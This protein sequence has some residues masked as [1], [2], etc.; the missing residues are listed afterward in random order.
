M[1]LFKSF[2]SKSIIAICLS[3][4]FVSCSKDDKSNQPTPQISQIEKADK[5]AAAF[6]IK[7]KL[8]GMAVASVKDDEL[9][10]SK[11]YGF[12]NKETN[13]PATDESVF[14]IASISK[15]ITGVATMQLVEDGLID[16]DANI[17]TYLPF[18]VTNPNSPSKPITC[19]MLMTHTSGITDT[20]YNSIA[21]QNFYTVGGQDSPISLDAFCR[22]FFTQGGSYY[23]TTTYANTSAGTSYSYTNLGI[24]LLGY[25]VEKVSGKLFYQYTNEEI[26]TPLG[27]TKTSWR[28][29]DFQP[30]QLAMTYNATNVPFGLYTFAD[31]PNGALRTS[32]KDLS[33]FMR[34]IMLG[35]SFNNKQILKQSSVTEMLKI[36]YPKV[37][38]AEGQGLVFY[39]NVNLKL[40][41]IETSEVFMGHEG[42]EQGVLTI[43]FFDPITKAGS[44]IFI[45]KDLD[46]PNEQ[47]KE[48]LK[49]QYS[50]LQ[51]AKNNYPTIN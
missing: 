42:G 21:E 47:Q 27:M 29:Q 37:L 1:E 39:K 2:K 9:I 12:A 34:A 31:Y 19:R 16:L 30:S 24:A 48:G 23:N 8:M 50:L 43:M 17:N 32:V 3:F 20:Y 7:N 28:L 49:L 38:G 25:I 46:N 10:F 51:L 41:G 45:N 18:A 36:Q 40:V 33:K 13:T 44:I 11:G 14:L 6:L 5:D 35:G 22:G 15:T 4:I 26:F